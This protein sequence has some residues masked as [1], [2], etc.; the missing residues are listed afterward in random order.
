[1]S[2][3]WAM[4]KEIQRE[5]DNPLACFALADLLEEEGWTDL[6][7][8]YRWMGWYRRRPGHREG[9]RLR[10]RFV[11][12]K[13]GAFEGWPTDESE[14][15]DALPMARLHPLVFQSMATGNAQYDLYA[16]WQQA[17]KALAQGLARLRGLLQPPEETRKERGA[18][19][20]E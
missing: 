15:Y 19:A 8:C 1:M 14:R 20:A 11:W 3:K 10:K 16:T 6:S 13:E 5:P 4:M 9:P 12:Y 17:V 2:A 18:D 7:F